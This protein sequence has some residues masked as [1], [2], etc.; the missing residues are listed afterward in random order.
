[1][2]GYYNNM[3]KFIYILLWLIGGFG[4]FGLHRFYLGFKVSGFIWLFSL[5]GML[6]GAIYDIFN[7]DKLIAESEG[8]EYKPKEKKAK[9]QKVSKSKNEINIP[10]Q[11]VKNGIIVKYR[12]K[13]IG[14]DQSEIVPAGTESEARRIIKAKYPTMDV[15]IISTMYSYA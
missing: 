11:K 4:M 7:I 6:I 10:K 2:D 5:G 3:K 13:T 1:M 14:T 12:I 15:H 8:N 9:K